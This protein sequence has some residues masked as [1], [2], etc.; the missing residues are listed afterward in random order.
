MSAKGALPSSGKQGLGREVTWLLQAGYC[1][2]QKSALDREITFN[3]HLYECI[4]ILFYRERERSFL[5][6]ME[7][8]EM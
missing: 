7:C 4:I 6:F 2:S 3:Y 5:D 1:Q 8:Y